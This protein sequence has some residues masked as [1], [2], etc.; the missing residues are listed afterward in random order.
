MSGNKNAFFH[1][2]FS[3]NN[4]YVIGYCYGGSCYLYKK[5]SQNEYC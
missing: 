1:S 5:T 4:E 2:K 3:P